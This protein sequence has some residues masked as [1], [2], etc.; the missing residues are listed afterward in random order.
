MHSPPLLQVETLFHE[1]G[2]V[3]HHLLSNTR[4]HR[5]ASFRCEGD[6]VEAPSQV[7]RRAL[8]KLA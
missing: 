6:F 3:M 2:H 7:R 4:L 1:F 8:A 5:W